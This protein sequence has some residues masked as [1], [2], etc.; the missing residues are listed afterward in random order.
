M[1]HSLIVG[2]MF[3]D[4]HS[5]SLQVTHTIPLILYIL[6]FS[7]CTNDYI[8]ITNFF[9]FS[10][11]IRFAKHNAYYCHRYSYCNDY[12]CQSYYVYL[13]VFHSFVF[14]VNTVHF[15]CR[16]VVNITLLLRPCRLL[17]PYVYRHCAKSR[18]NRHVFRPCNLLLIVVDHYRATPHAN[19]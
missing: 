15:T 19:R 13:I 3:R 9:G 5:Q 1:Q 18:T 8:T 17:F 12:H 7:F 16:V 4:Q 2:L 6:P 14:F 10:T 11:A